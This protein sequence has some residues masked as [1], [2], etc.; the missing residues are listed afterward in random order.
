M[1]SPGNGLVEVNFNIPVQPGDR[2]VVVH[3]EECLN[4]GSRLLLTLEPVD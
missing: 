4:D 2:F 3:Q 1:A